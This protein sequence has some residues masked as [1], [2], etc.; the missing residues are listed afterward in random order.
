MAQRFHSS[1]PEVTQKVTLH[2][3][4]RERTTHQIA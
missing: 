2:A 3:S 4:A 1:D